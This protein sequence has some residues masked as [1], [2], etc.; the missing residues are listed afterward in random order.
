MDVNPF[1]LFRVCK[2]ITDVIESE[3][4]RNKQ[5]CDKCKQEWHGCWKSDDVPSA[6][7]STDG[8]MRFP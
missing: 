1:S 6:V 8:G 2:K 4:D 3:N 5:V 7:E